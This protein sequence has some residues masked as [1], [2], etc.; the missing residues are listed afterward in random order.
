MSVA[1]EFLPKS[2]DL[3]EVSRGLNRNDKQ[4]WKLKVIGCGGDF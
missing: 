1:G 3:E 2:R 4:I